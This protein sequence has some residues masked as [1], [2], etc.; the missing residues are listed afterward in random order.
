MTWDS[1]VEVVGKRIEMKRKALFYDIDGT[2][3]SEITGEIPQS[4][5]KALEKARENGH[6]TFINTGRTVAGMPYEFKKMPFSGYVCGCGT[7]IQYGDA[8]LM[9]RHIP[10]E[11]GREIVRCIKAARA[12]MILEGMEDCYLPERRSRFERL[13]NTR[14]YFREMGLG[15]EHYAEDD[16]FDFDKFVVYTDEMTDKQML[17]RNLE[18]DMEIMDRQNGLY[19]VV[20][21]EFSKASGIAFVLK[22]FGLEPEDAYVFGDSSNDLSMFRFVPHAAA[23]GNHDPVLDPYTEFVTK[24]VEQDGIEWA[25]RHYGLI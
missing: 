16:G 9:T 11:R 19:E 20:P 15:I 24:T 14:R 7:Y 13:E 8:V 3:L 12:D 23:M 21:G 4:A 1:D 5:Q 18:R 6:L 10:H 25:M 2:L 17:F 22:H